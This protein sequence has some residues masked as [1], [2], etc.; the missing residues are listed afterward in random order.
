MN[1]LELKSSLSTAAAPLPDVITCEEVMLLWEQMAEKLDGD[2]RRFA[3]FR[4]A[5]SSLVESV[6]SKASSVNKMLAALADPAPPIGEDLEELI[7]EADEMDSADKNPASFDCVDEATD[8]VLKKR[9]MELRV[10]QDNGRQ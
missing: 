8:V 3:T 7:K 4:N 6:F 9:E 1:E 10:Q 5:M 2:S